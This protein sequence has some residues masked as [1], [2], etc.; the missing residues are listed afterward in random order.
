MSET[1]PTGPIDTGA[2]GPTE[3][4]ATGTG[5]T[6]TYPYYM[7]STPPPPDILTLS[8][9]LNDQ[10]I[11]V[12]KEQADKA[13]LETIGTQSVMSL[14]PKLVEW[15]LKGRPSAFPLVSVNIT[16]PPI[17][18]DG[19]VRGLLDYIQ[20]CS[21]KTLN[22]HVSLLRAKLPDIDISYANIQG[23]ITVV[24]VMV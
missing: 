5:P 1:G 17:C 14:R 16:P 21:G 6:G 8:D 2:T 22:E 13:L 9:L 23:A 4:G 3:T 7:E 24:T 12:S 19:E 18:S 11:V 15:I 10:S 20:F